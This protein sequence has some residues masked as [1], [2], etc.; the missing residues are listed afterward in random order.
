MKSAIII[1]FILSFAGI[2]AFGV[3]TMNHGVDHDNRSS[4]CLEAIAR[5]VDCPKQGDAVSFTIFHLD[6]LRSFF[7]AVFGQD[8]TSSFLLVAVLFALAGVAIGTLHTNP[9]PIDFH[10][11]LKRFSDLSSLPFRRHIIRWLSLFEHSPP[12]NYGA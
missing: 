7:T 5:G 3:F 6:V 12:L 4:I 1:F 9:G 10:I 11:R 8:T 2:I